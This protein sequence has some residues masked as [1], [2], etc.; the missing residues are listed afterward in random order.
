MLRLHGTA[1]IILATERTGTLARQKT[2]GAGPLAY[3][4]YSPLPAFPP[5]SSSG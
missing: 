2:G 5:S 1:S 3:C 4:W